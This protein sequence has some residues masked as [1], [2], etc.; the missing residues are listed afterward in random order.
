MTK[1][2]LVSCG[3]CI[4]SQLKLSK[5]TQFIT[6]N[7]CKNIFKVLTWTFIWCIPFFVTLLISKLHASVVYFICLFLWLGFWKFHNDRYV[8]PFE[9]RSS[10]QICLSLKLFMLSN[11]HYF[12][13]PKLWRTVWDSYIMNG[14]IHTKSNKVGRSRNSDRA[15]IWHTLPWWVP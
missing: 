9:I 14:S 4:S 5:L 15:E 8:A 6:F 11:D 10:Y 13:Y 1:S 7:D 3:Y 2:S 12:K